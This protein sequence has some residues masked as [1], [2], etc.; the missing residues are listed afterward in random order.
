[1]SL[2]LTQ[3][4]SCASIA[5][6]HIHVWR[7]ERLLVLFRHQ[8]DPPSRKTRDCKF[9]LVTP[10]VS[11]SAFYWRLFI[12]QQFSTHE[13]GW[14]MEGWEESGQCDHDEERVVSFSCS[15]SSH[16][17]LPPPRPPPFCSYKESQF[18]LTALKPFLFFFISCYERLLLIRKLWEWCHPHL[19]T[20]KA[21]TYS[22]TA[23]HR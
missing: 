13:R 10:A 1:M 11:K 20:A 12:F 9:L 7:L 18:Q 6:F 21:M 23:L 15:S 17:L 5:C 16:C 19:A 14:G 4:C 22:G 3:M 2:S 8:I